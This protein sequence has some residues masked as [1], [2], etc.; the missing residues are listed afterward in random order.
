MGK[1][2]SKTIRNYEKIYEIKRKKLIKTLKQKRLSTIRCI[3]L[4]KDFQEYLDIEKTLLYL[5]CNQFEV[6]ATR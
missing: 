1:E 5:Y 4:E 2:M 6:G 3:E